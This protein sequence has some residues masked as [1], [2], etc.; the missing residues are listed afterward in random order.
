MK[1]FGHN[2]GHYGWAREPF[3]L[4]FVVPLLAPS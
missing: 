1:Q 4:A 3:L 2:G